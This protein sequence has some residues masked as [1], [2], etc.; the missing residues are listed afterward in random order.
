MLIKEQNRRMVK[1]QF[2]NKLKTEHG[3]SV[4]GAPWQMAM[5]S[6]AEGCSS[7]EGTR[8]GW[9]KPGLKG[10]EVGIGRCARV[11]RFGWKIENQAV[12]ARFSR[13]KHGGACI[14]VEGIQLG[15]GKLGFKG[16]DVGIDRCARVGGFGWKIEN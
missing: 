15:W 13:T 3:G 4:S 11:G 2:K 7:V 8:L 16:W 9:G 10:W 1:L 6:D 5:E 12:R 14:W